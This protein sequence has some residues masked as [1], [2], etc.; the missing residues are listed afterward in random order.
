MIRLVPAKC[1]NCGAQLELDD[2]LK[3]TQCKYCRTTIIVDDAIEKY[4]VELSGKI[5]VEGIKNR[6]D[7]LKQAKKHFKVEEYEKAKEYLNKIIQEDKFDIEAYSELIK[8]DIELLKQKDYEL[9]ASTMNKK[10][11]THGVVYFDE[12]MTT[13][14]RIKK[15]DEEH[16][17][18]KYLKGYEAEL[19]HYEEYYQERMEEKKEIAK[20]V[21]Q[22]NQDYHEAKDGGYLPTFFKAVADAFEFGTS[23]EEV[24]SYAYYGTLSDNY[25]LIDFKDIEVDGFVFMNYEKITNNFT[26]NPKKTALTKISTRPVGTFRGLT[27][28]YE[29]YLKLFEQGKKDYENLLVKKEKSRQRSSFFSKISAGLSVVAAIILLLVNISAFQDGLG[30]FILFLF[31]VDSWAVPVVLYWVV[32]AFSDV[33]YYARKKK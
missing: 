19:K 20:W 27:N 33:S 31:M 13:Y 17:A 9:Y 16:E 14:H 26:A 8:C 1:P 5:E 21:K 23:L 12:L 7:F 11:D 10:V 3:K 32:S 25:R 24:T 2:N 30:T 18:E 15:I 29:T 4:Q 28:R 6:N 22:L